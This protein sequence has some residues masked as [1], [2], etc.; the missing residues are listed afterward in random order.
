MSHVKRDTIEQPGHT[1][2]DEEHAIREIQGQSGWSIALCR[3][4]T[5]ISSS[6]RTRSNKDPAERMT[7]WIWNKACSLNAGRFL[8]NTNG[9][10]HE[11]SVH[12]DDIVS[13]CSW[14][15]PQLDSPHQLPASKNDH[16]VGDD[17]HDDLSRGAQRGLARN[18]MCQLIAG[19]QRIRG[20][21]RE[22]GVDRARL[23][24]SERVE[25]DGGLGDSYRK[26]FR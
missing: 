1:R 13:L 20:D 10:T 8:V 15:R 24:K 22:E 23:V 3:W 4:M 25:H 16:Q 18:P 17:G 12:R 2:R 11:G 7:L 9:E 26:K 21:R 14:S 19:L 5:D 6:M